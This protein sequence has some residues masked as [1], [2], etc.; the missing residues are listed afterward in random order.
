MALGHPEREIARIGTIRL[1]REVP[2]R[3]ETLEVLAQTGDLARP[4]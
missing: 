2:D 4:V 3:L 1:E